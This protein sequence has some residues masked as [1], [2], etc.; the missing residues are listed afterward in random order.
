MRR[1]IA[2]GLLLL[3]LGTAAAAGAQDGRSWPGRTITYFETPRDEGVR[4][5]AKAWSRSGIRIRFRRAG[6]R[7]RA[8]VLVRVGGEGCGGFAQLGYAPGRQALMR[9]FECPRHDQMLVSAHEFGHILGLS[10]ENRRCALMNPV[11]FNGAPNRC[12]PPEQGEYRCRVFERHDLRRA[13]RKYGGSTRYR[14]PANCALFGPPPALDRLETVSEDPYDL[15]VLITAPVAPQARVET[16]A[17][18]FGPQMR[19]QLAHAP[20][21]CPVDPVAIAA[22]FD[23]ALVR[24]SPVGWERT[25]EDYL[26]PHEGQQ[27]VAARIVDDQRVGTPSLAEV[28]PPVPAN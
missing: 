23:T 24:E 5:A 10:H 22:M 27:C 2:G 7:R 8:D 21:P 18:A 20:G 4:D 14:K 26:S 11:M 17:S 9:V 15:R 16:F 6:S 25:D 1:A 3:S 13:K 28:V 19:T 12:R